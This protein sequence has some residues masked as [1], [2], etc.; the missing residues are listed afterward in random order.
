M[1]KKSTVLLVVLAVVAVSLWAY[2]MQVKPVE[3]SPSTLS[4]A[5]PLASAPPKAT[6]TNTSKTGTTTTKKVSTSMTYAQALNAYANSRMQFDSSCFANPTSLHIRNGMNVLLDN[7]A[8][9]AISVKVDGV[10]YSLGGYGFKVIMLSHKNLPYTA[11]VDCGGGVN[12]AQI[13]L[14]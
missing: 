11:G 6:S 9:N 13:L 7:R 2:Y 1:M 5:V 8:P 3:P 10:A 4:S 12:T 14:Q